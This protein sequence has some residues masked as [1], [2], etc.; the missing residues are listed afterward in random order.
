M[1]QKAAYCCLNCNNLP[2]CNAA[3]GNCL[4]CCQDCG[5]TSSCIGGAYFNGG[6]YKDY[7][8]TVAT[9]SS[10]M[11][12]DIGGDHPTVG[13]FE[14][15]TSI[16]NS[17]KQ[18]PCEKNGIKIYQRGGGYWIDESYS[19]NGPTTTSI[20]DFEDCD[21][22]PQITTGPSNCINSGPITETQCS[23]PEE[24]FGCIVEVS[25]NPACCGPFGFCPC[26]NPTIYRANSK[27][28]SEITF[29]NPVNLYNSLGENVGNIIGASYNSNDPTRGWQAPACHFFAP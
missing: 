9:S 14:N 25:C 17:S 19:Y 4:P 12:A 8:Y 16:Y 13:G 20:I 10:F 11:F 15:Y 6:F 18:I 21:D 23:T 22:C 3:A 28:K 24:C 2:P 5:D 1:D 27:Y 7:I 29:I 26:D